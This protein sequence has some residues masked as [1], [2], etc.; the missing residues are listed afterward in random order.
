MRLTH[1]LT[2]L[3]WTQP[4]ALYAMLM[5]VFAPLSPSLPPP[6][7]SCSISYLLTIMTPHKSTQVR[8]KKPPLPP[9]KKEGTQVTVVGA[10]LSNRMLQKIQELIPVRK[11]LNIGIWSTTVHTTQSAF[12]I[13]LYGWEST[14]AL[15]LGSSVEERVW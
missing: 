4:L 5:Y 11:Q 1:C 13:N 15:Y 10:T 14:L 7:L 6:L 3:L 9:A 12:C 2:T 8:S